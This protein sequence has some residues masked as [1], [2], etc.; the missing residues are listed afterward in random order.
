[1]FDYMR[2]IEIDYM[3]VIEISVIALVT[4]FFLPTSVTFVLITEF[5][6]VR[7][8]LSNKIYYTRSKIIDIWNSIP[9]SI[10]HQSIPAVPTP[11]GNSEAFSRTVHPGGRALAFH[12]IIPGHLTISL[13]FFLPYNIVASSNDQMIGKFGKFL[14]EYI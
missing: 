7:A 5:I 1:M 3:R 6:T 12:P 11:R 14:L 9:L 4:M 2:V 13:F 10:M 8:G